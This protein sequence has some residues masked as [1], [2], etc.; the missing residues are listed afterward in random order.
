MALIHPTHQESYEEYHEF[1]RCIGRVVG[2]AV[3]A[4]EILFNP[5]F[6]NNL[7]QQLTANTIKEIVLG[8]PKKIGK[9]GGCHVMPPDL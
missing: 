4:G 8:D 6:I 3:F 5:I 1:N 2:A 7:L 9:E